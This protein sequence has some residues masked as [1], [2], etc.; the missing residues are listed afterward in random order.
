MADFLRKWRNE[1][2]LSCEEVDHELSFERG[3]TARFEAQGIV[4]IPMDQ[5]MKLVTLYKVPAD[6]LFSALDSE[7]KRIRN[8]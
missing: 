4:R 2:N 8:P 3:A 6:A 5:L 7:I 1:R